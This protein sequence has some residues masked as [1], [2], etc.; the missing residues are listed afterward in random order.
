M[1]ERQRRDQAERE[2]S[3]LRA[4][5]ADERAAREAEE[6]EAMRLRDQ[7]EADRQ[8]RL[9]AS[10]RLEELR[11]SY[12][13]ALN[14]AGSQS[15]VEALRRQVEDQQLSLNAIRERGE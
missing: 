9:E 13:S 3:E 2:A 1:A 7:L 10:A 15:E 12:E 11:T 4:R 14:R 5:L 8:A 6:Q